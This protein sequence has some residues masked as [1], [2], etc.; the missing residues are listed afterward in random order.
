MALSPETLTTP[1]APPGAVAMAA[2]VFNLLS[3]FVFYILSSTFV[4]RVS[5]LF[6]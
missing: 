4:I 5:M 3:R 1:M 6:L 2:I